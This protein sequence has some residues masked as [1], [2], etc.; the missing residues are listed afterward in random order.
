MVYLITEQYPRQI[1]GHPAV[2][3]AMLPLIL[4]WVLRLW[5]IAVHGRLAEDPVVFALRD[6]FSL[7]TGVVLFLVLLAAWS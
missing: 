1:Y 6:T 4:V 3:W 7:G 2:L 5:H